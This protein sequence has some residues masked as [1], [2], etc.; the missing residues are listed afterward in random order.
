MLLVNPRPRL[1]LMT[2]RALS[3]LV[4]TTVLGAALAFGGE[5][6]WARPVLASLLALLAL[7]WL[8]RVL[9]LRR[10]RLLKSPLAPLGVMA[11]M[12]GL[13]QLTPL[14]ASLAAWLAPRARAA[15]TLGVLPDRV[16]T[17]DPSAVLPE[18]SGERTPATLD[19]SATLRWLAGASGCLALFCVAAH[20][21]D[22]LGHALVIWGSV[23][24]AFFIN[25]VFALVQLT[26]HAGGLY[27]SIEPGK[28]APW[29]PSLADALHAPGVSVLR[30]A[31]ESGRGGT[32]WAVAQPDPPFLIGTLMG[33]PGAYL[34]LGALAL[35]LAL[36]LTLQT[37]A[38]RGSREGT[39]TRLRNSG[40]AGLVLFL[41]VLVLAGAGVVGLLAGP[42][43]A[44]PFALGLVLAGLPAA[45][46]SGLRWNAV[47]LTLG[48]LLVLGLGVAL[49]DA[50]GRP[51]G[52]SPFTTPATLAE[53]RQ[54]WKDSVR[55][56][57]DFPILG[58]GMGSFHAIFP[59]YKGRDLT[60]STAQSSLLQWGVEG[61]AAALILTALGGLWCLI[62]LP[63][64]VRRVGTADRA[65]PFALIGSA[66]CFT[67]FSTL[68]WS[69]ELAAV[70][71]AAS[72][73]A[74][75]W[76]RWLA[77]GTDLFI[78]RT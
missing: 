72:A 58:S 8:V 41:Y 10:W 49:G 14:P 9:L 50:Q 70:A 46:A 30:L 11:L 57:R 27:G 3:A 26:V 68:H 62:R 16:L 32:V 39:W 7:A 17:D 29:T 73:L 67:L 69:I 61:G 31:T 12:L 44:L 53:A 25:T 65:L 77:G 60:S 34:A 20:F 5:V 78:A 21:A 71:L 47:G 6:W 51:P 74:G 42:W 37:L 23:V 48:V 40:Q 64:A 75:T 76:N 54:T 38:P 56:W 22:R 28:G 59:Y 15:H 19:R 55:I 4:A 63:G 1:L 33:G 66:L 13:L 45:W 35:P 52:S 43:L 36:G 2:D 24:A 18:A